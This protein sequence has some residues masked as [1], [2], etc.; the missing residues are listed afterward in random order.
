MYH[1]VYLNL[2]Y[3]FPESE[4]IENGGTKVNRMNNL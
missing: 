1:G 2:Y 4:A 3:I